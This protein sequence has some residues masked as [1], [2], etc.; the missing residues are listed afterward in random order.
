MLDSQ[1]NQ[2]SQV[3]WLLSVMADLPWVQETKV[4]VFTPKSKDLLELE[5]RYGYR[6]SY[7]NW[8]P[9]EKRSLRRKAAG[10]IQNQEE[11][12]FANKNL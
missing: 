9:S 2:R 12:N 10:E 5:E 1:E 4:F 3:E 11:L 7:K 6:Y 8:N